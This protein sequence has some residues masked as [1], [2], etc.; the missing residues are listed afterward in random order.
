[1]D[2]NMWHLWT[3]R[4]MIYMYTVKKRVLPQHTLGV[5]VR[6]FRNN[7]PWS[8]E[9]TAQ[10]CYSQHPWS[11]ASTLYR[12]LTKASIVRQK[13]QLLGM[14]C[15]SYATM[16]EQWECNPDCG[17]MLSFLTYM[18][19]WSTLRAPTLKNLWRPTRAL[20]PGHTLLLVMS[21]M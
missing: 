17:P 13:L 12:V 15:D 14:C 8:V 20:M 9:V 1:M 2:K 7:T 19:T 10:G 21:Q 18:R 11:V 3:G 5:S 16:S 6:L 4:A